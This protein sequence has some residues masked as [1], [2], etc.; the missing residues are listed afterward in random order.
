MPYPLPRLQ[1]EA[2]EAEAAEG[3]PTAHQVGQ[4]PPL[5]GWLAIQ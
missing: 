3:Q 5:E 1:E 2:E 4:L